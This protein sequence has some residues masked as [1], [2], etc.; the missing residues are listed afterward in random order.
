MCVGEKTKS[1]TETL[2]SPLTPPP[3]T[4]WPSL[5]SLLGPSPLRLGTKSDTRVKPYQRLRLMT[6]MV[7]VLVKGRLLLR[8]AMGYISSRISSFRIFVSENLMKI[9]ANNHFNCRK[10][11]YTLEPFLYLIVSHRLL[12]AA[13][14]SISEYKTGEAART[15][16]HT[17]GFFFCLHLLNRGLQD[18][19]RW[20]SVPR[21]ATDRNMIT[22]SFFSVEQTKFYQLQRVFCRRRNNCRQ[23]TPRF[24]RGGFA[25]V[26]VW[27]RSTS[28][29]H[30]T[31]APLTESMFFCPPAGRKDGVL[32]TRVFLCSDSCAKK[33]WSVDSVDWTLHRPNFDCALVLTRT[34]SIFVFVTLESVLTGTRSDWSTDCSSGTFSGATN[35]SATSMTNS[36]SFGPKWRSPYRQGRKFSFFCYVSS[37]LSRVLWSVQVHV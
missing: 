12:C 31:T 19:Q 17:Q 28:D 37:G 20:V 16:L 25:K 22:Q 8:V 11:L 23:C 24:F 9:F 34:R 4:L 10:A 2:I 7:S 33:Q 14:M 36:C 27:K 18:E 3:T 6:N 32:Y 13:S 15:R 1:N 29:L 21:R 26:S 5:W 30:K 35:T